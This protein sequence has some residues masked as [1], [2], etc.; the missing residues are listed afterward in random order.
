[1]ESLEPLGRDAA[2][3]SADLGEDRDDGHGDREPEQREAGHGVVL[4]PDECGDERG[5]DGQRRQGQ[6][7]P[8]PGDAG[9]ERDRHH[10]EREGN[11]LELGQHQ[12]G[13]EDRDDAGGRGQGPSRERRAPGADLLQH[14]REPPV[15]QHERGKTHLLSPAQAGGERDRGGDGHHQ[16][17]PDT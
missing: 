16:N 7:R 15:A 12:R 2:A 4:R 1:M 11:R 5:E 3:A 9:G 6:A 8:E 10:V 13:D 14:R 17:E